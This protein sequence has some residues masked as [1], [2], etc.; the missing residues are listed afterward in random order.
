M[1]KMLRMLIVAAS[2]AAVLAL[3]AGTFA[4]AAGPEAGCDAAYCG[5]RIG[6]G[7]QGNNIEIFSK[8]TGL[9]M[10]QIQTLR[11]EGK[12]LVQ[13]AATKGVNEQKLV[14][15]IISA[16]KAEIQ[17]RVTAGT[18]TQEQANIM[19]QQMEQNVVQAVNR[20]ATGQ[21]DWA[22]K[23]AGQCAGNSQAGIQG[24]GIQQTGYGETGL[25]TG[26]GNMN[27]WGKASR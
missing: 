11:H 15:A 24:P 23:G 4:A 6:S 8:V 25:C 12:S 10:E 14:A 1:G 3:S 19:L 5:Q 7:W 17:A 13:I 16:R 9:T 20:T 18:L 21:P 27:K 2:M 26:P 22:G